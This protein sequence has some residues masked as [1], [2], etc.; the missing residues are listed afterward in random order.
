LNPSSPRLAGRASTCQQNATV[1]DARDGILLAS[2]DEE[3]AFCGS[4]KEHDYEGFEV[5]ARLSQRPR[6]I[7]KEVFWFAPG[8]PVFFKKEL[9]LPLTYPHA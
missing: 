3:Q 8:V 7:V 5:W 4:N 1:L 2:R 9:L 6:P